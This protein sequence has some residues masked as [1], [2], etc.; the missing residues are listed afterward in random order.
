MALYT[1]GLI[2]NGDRALAPGW[3]DRRPNMSGI[4]AVWQWINLDWALE[5]IGPSWQPP[6]CPLASPRCF[7]GVLAAPGVPRPSLHLVP[8]VMV[9]VTRVGIALCYELSVGMGLQSI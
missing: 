7:L 1:A 5:L 2:I 9:G 3:Y 4:S 6:A 8:I